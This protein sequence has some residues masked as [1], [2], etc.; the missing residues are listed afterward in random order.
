MSR[1]VMIDAIKAYLAEYKDKNE[2]YQELREY[3][4]LLILK[5]LDENGYFQHLAFVG[6]TALRIL[7]NLKR[8][9]EDL[10]FSLINAKNYSFEMIMQ[11]LTK[12]LAKANLKVTITY[13]DNKSVAS[14][15][16][17]FD[18]LLYALNLSSHKD[19]KLAIKF[20]VDQNPPAGFKTE[21]SVINKA[22]LVGI[23]H[24]DLPSLYA[25]KL[26]AVL[27]RPYAKGRDY[28]DLLW[29]I[30][31]NVKPNYQLLE[32]AYIQTEHTKLKIDEKKLRELLSE[33]FA[34]TNFKKISADVEPF[35]QNSSEL[36]FFD[37]AI[38][39]D[40]IKK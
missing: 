24:Y 7:Y 5:L 25:G 4:Q 32:N 31:R 36:R 33:K 13:K 38:F 39:L 6:G 22:F 27:C 17:K 29:Y 20:E 16:I 23:N 12:L 34:A 10:D 40:L 2:K 21:F 37:K 9:S 14:A 19:Q 11:Q 26:H 8:F 28:Y 1:Q 18:E 30:G 15:F 35:L 3:L